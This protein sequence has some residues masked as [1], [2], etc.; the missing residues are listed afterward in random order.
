MSFNIPR[1]APIVQYETPATGATVSVG[2]TGFVKV[3]I[4]P[5]GTLLALTFALPSSPNDGDEVVLTSSQIVTTF[6]M[7]GGT[8]VGPLSTLAVATFAHYTYFATPAKWFRT[9]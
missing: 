7:T 5:S 1:V 2:S 9:G 6:T 4:N 8:I 3:C